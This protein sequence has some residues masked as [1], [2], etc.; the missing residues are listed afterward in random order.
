MREAHQK[1]LNP[2]PFPLNEIFWLGDKFFMQGKVDNPPN[3]L[4]CV[5]YVLLKTL[6][7]AAIRISEIKEYNGQIIPNVNVYTKE[8]NIWI[9]PF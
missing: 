6:F 2:T 8:G 4:I 9:T 3:Y 5:F 1:N 7:Y